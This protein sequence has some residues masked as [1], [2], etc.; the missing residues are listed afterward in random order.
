[1]LARVAFRADLT[2]PQMTQHLPD[3]AGELVRR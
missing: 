3:L 2:H 1:L